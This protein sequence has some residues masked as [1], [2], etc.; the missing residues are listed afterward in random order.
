MNS[1][2]NGDH[3]YGPYVYVLCRIGP[4]LRGMYDVY[5]NTQRK[6]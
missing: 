5:Y 6:D 3:H 4:D 1:Y 2:V